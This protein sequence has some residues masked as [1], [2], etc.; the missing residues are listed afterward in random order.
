MSFWT[1]APEVPHPPPEPDGNCGA[2][3]LSWN[4]RITSAR[5][6]EDE[7]S[8]RMRSPELWGIRDT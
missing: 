3:R 8:T 6:F 4:C 7:V 2:V 5:T 1:D